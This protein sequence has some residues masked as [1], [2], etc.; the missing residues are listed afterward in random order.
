MSTSSIGDV[1]RGAVEAVD[2]DG[3]SSEPIKIDLKAMGLSSHS[4]DCCDCLNGIVMSLRGCATI[5]LNATISRSGQCPRSC[6]LRV[7]LRFLPFWLS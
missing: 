3:L 4:S 1:P 5:A 2:V 7:A 6:R